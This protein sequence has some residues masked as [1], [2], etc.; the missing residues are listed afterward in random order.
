MKPLPYCSILRRSAT[1]IGL[2]LCLSVAAQAQDLRISTSADITGL[3]PHDTT[4]NTSYSIQSGIFERLFQFDNEMKLIS[5]LATD[6]VGNDNATEFTLTLREGVTF[7]DGT[8]F[9]AEAVKAN[10]GRLAD[11]SK[12]LKRNSLFKMIKSITALSPTQVKIELNQPFGAFINTLA[13]PSAVMHSPAALAQ[14]PEEAQLRQHPVGTGPFKF[15]EWQLGKSIKLSK[16][17]GYWRQGWPKVDNVTFYP[18]PEDATRVAALKA[19]QVDAISPLPTDL[20]E[21]IKNDAKLAVQRDKSI[22][23]TYVAINTQHTAF[24][25]VRVRQALNYAINRDVW[26]KVGYAG[27]GTTA[28]STLSPNVQFYQKQT[29]PDYRYDP[30]KAKALLK[31]AGYGNGLDTIMYTLNSTASIRN[32]QFLK[33]Q[34]GQVGVR[35]TVMPMDAG[36]RNKKI[37]GNKDPQKAEYDFY[38]GGW[39]PSTGDAD[40]ALRPLF[41]TESWVPTAQNMSYYSGPETDKYITAALQTAD[42]AKRAAA[43]AEAQ[44][45]IWQDAPVIFLGS[46]DNLVGK[47]KNLNNVYMQ[48]DGLLMYSRAE[49]H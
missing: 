26:L 44:K 17:A 28:T 4:D 12:G 30:E 5:W 18:T 16:Y 11:P 24:N 42:P 10:L 7:Q 19:G 1:A 25:D 33:Q 47:V 14:Y 3:D 36:T 43:Y 15:V 8:P 45:Q 31:E 49:F 22:Y 20:M 38:F 2:S 35:V 46:P 34:L 23:F 32:T 21:T 13:H 6:Y 41:A 27:M 29:A 37:F 48:A 39:S 9:D 40:W